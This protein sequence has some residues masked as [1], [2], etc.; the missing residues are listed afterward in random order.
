M[1]Y[2]RIYS[3]SLPAN[4]FLQTFLKSNDSGCFWF[5]HPL[6]CLVGVRYLWQS[7]V[8]HWRGSIKRSLE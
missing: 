6:Q 1:G 2:I 5:G 4:V 8:G 3:N 7:M